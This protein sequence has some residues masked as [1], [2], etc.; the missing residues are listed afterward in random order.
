MRPILLLAL[1]TAAAIAQAQT[2]Q[3]PAPPKPDPSR[4]I[5][6]HRLSSE[7]GTIY[8]S[9]KLDAD[10]GFVSERASW[11]EG[12]YGETNRPLSVS[13]EWHPEYGRLRFEQG[14]ANF[15]FAETGRSWS[16][17]I[18]LRF[19]R[20]ATLQHSV[21]AGTGYEKPTAITAFLPVSDLIKAIGAAEQIDLQITGGGGKIAA[22]KY[23]RN[24][25]TG[26][27]RDAQS[28]LPKEAGILDV[29]QANYRSACR[30]LT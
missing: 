13:I 14:F 24:Y 28:A 17:P 23:V 22:P 2:V 1:L 19:L 30:P 26:A 4:F 12:P 9:R 27:L 5:C 11:V 10:G 6:T 29:M 8:S 18:K 15:Y 3:A 16:H 25:P 20:N 21:D 7:S